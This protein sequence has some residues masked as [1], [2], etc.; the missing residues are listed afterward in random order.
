MDKTVTDNGITGKHI[1]KQLAIALK[2]GQFHDTENTVVVSSIEEFLEMI[3]PAIEAEGVQTVELAGEMFYLNGTLIKYPLE[4]SQNFDFLIREFQ[5]KDLGS[6]SFSSSLCMDDVKAFLKIFK[7]CMYSETPFEDIKNSLESIENI[8]ADRL[9]SIKEEDNLDKRDFVAKTYFSAVSFTK[10]IMSKLAAGEK[11]SVKNAKRV[12]G[13]IIDAILTDEQF[14][15]GVSA[16][17][18]FD[19][20]TFHHCVNVSV[21]SIAMG[22]KLGLKGKALV[23]LGFAA[24][25]HDIGKKDIPREVLNKPG[26]F[27]D[28]EWE[29]MKKHPRLGALSILKLKDLDETLIRNALVAVEHHMQNDL[30]GYP[31]LQSVSTLNLYSKIVTIADQYDA[32]TASRVYSRTPHSPDKALKIMKE[33]AGSY[34]DPGLFKLFVNMV[35]VFPVGS[36]VFLSSGEMGLVYKSNKTVSDK[37]Q[38]MI[39]VNTAG[40]KIDGFVVDLMEKYSSG[41]FVRTIT[42]TVDPNKYGIN[43]A[44]YLF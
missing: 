41:T 14:L 10:G 37:P 23:N 13:T 43:L 12:V 28:E 39:I 7:E 6:V 29:I 2:Q 31:R 44:E 3:N 19:D 9:K 32:I 15:F 27:N 17:K 24:L 1:I 36:L 26:A 38:V 33:K 5:K 25:F 4:F 42:K 30:T 18:D 16:I 34:L 11:V 21:L 20:Y 40:E 8:D 22:Q 35:G